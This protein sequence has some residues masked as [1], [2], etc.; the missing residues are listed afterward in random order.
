MSNLLDVENLT[1]KFPTRQGMFEAVRNI[2]FSLGRERLGIVGESG[3]GKSITGRS[4]LRLIRHPG[5]LE[6]TRIALEGQ[7]A[8]LNV[9]AAAAVFL[10]EIRRRS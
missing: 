5:I 3:S 8:S 9:A 4:I 6:A 1:V 7:V 2:S 10:F